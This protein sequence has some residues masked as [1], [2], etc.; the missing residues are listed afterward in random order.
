M[1]YSVSILL[2]CN[3]KSGKNPEAAWEEN[4][5]LCDATSDILAKQKAEAVGRNLECE[6]EAANGDFLQW[7]YDSIMSVNKL[8]KDNIQD[9]DILFVRYLR[10]GEVSSLKQSFGD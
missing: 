7:K 2:K 9:K 5:V 3:S 8:E 10:D 1:W 6:Y 4:I